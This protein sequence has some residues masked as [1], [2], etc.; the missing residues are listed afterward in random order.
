MRTSVLAVVVAAGV[1]LAGGGRLRHLPAARPR[2]WWLVPVAVAAVAGSL[3]FSS[4]GTSLTVAALVA[5]AAFA[6]A[7]LR[8][9]GMAV[10]L[11]GLVLNIVVIL[12][13]GA[14]PV[15]RHA[16]VAAGLARSH[17]L[18]SL[19][20]GPSHRWHEAGDHVVALGDIVPVAALREVVS[21]GDLIVA[22]GLANVTF[23]LLRPLAGPPRATSS[24]RR[25]PRHRRA[26]LLS[27]PS[28][29]R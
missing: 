10:V 2:W 9:V 3:A 8:L 28:P 27:T 12:V 20:L 4:T 7:N 11:A 24:R 6:G 1:A 5:L 29:A 13:N 19:D 17:E 23:R 14:M 25:A 15:D 16:V 18:A 21:F 26:P 22:A